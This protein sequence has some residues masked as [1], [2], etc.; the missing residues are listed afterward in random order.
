MTVFVFP[1]VSGHRRQRLVNDFSVKRLRQTLESLALT[2]IESDLCATKPAQMA[3][4]FEA[5]LIR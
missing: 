1:T 5:P 4:C 2:D 3:T